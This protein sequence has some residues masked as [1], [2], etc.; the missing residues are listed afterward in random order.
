MSMQLTYHQYR[1]RVRKAVPLSKSNLDTLVGQVRSLLAQID[2]C[3]VRVGVLLDK[4]SC[5]MTS[6]EFAE[7]VPNEFGFSVR[8]AYYLID[9]AKTAK[10]HKI[11]SK[12]L[13]RVGWTKLA[14]M[15]SVL[16]SENYRDWFDA[17]EVT[18]TV[19]V[20]AM[21]KT[22][23]PKRMKH[24]TLI[25]PET[26]HAKMRGR[27]VKMGNDHVAFAKKVLAA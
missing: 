14:Y 7:L 18:N 20:K 11:P 1:P 27:L 16:T 23:T 12:Q 15:T 2:D 8:K 19:S 26:L 21:V 3:F 24:F 5:S 6:A 4:I 9:V 22:G 10:K 25:V 17:C 13:R